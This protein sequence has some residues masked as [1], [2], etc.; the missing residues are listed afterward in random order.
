MSDQKEIEDIWD[1][2][3]DDTPT[4]GE[5][6]NTQL[7]LQGQFERIESGEYIALKSH[8]LY[9]AFTIR[10]PTDRYHKP[11][12][13]VELVPQ[14]VEDFF[15]ALLNEMLS[16]ADA[17][18]PRSPTPTVQITR[19]TPKM[20]KEK[21]LRHHTRRQLL[22]WLLGIETLQ[23]V[24]QVQFPSQDKQHPIEA[25]VIDGKICMA[26]RY[27]SQPLL[28]TQLK[29]E[30]AELCARLKE[31]LIAQHDNVSEG[32]DSWQGIL[33]PS[34]YEL[35]AME[36]GAL[37]ELLLRL[38]K[39]SATQ[40]TEHI[41]PLEAKAL[42]I[43]DLDVL[44]FAPIDFFHL[45]DDHFSSTPEDLPSHIVTT[46]VEPF[47][48]KGWLMH[49]IHPLHPFDAL[50]AQSSHTSHTIHSASQATLFGNASCQLIESLGFSTRHTCL[51]TIT[52]HVCS[53]VATDR[54]FISAHNFPVEHFAHIIGE[55]LTILENYPYEEPELS[56]TQNN[57]KNYPH[58]QQELSETHID[59]GPLSHHVPGCEAVV[60]YSRR[61]EDNARSSWFGQA[62]DEPSALAESFIAAKS[63][64]RAVRASLEQFKL[65]S[66]DH[67]Q[68]QEFYVFNQDHVCLL[69]PLPNVPNHFA[70]WLC[71]WSG[72]IGLLRAHAMKNARA[73]AI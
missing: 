15:D 22:L 41:Y 71:T 30:H 72:N 20:L 70:I 6:A 56:D 38:L 62:S 50:I 4:T 8:D 12:T 14:D 36:R 7:G 23:G 47:Q 28:D 1:E 11:I 44:A 46:L 69:L 3:L 35:D 29:R 60:V 68:I 17:R 31:T 55:T 73:F 57:L 40:H 27:T 24:H 54:Q 65:V 53:L 10:E 39:H 5:V 63:R 18:A 45:L 52:E 9:D 21:A 59:L 48:G 16:A 34:D 64:I 2:L 67:R 13:E 25:L 51:C 42:A 58:E 32:D 19:P 26:M 49:H 66:E 61:S 43:K 37:S 33:L